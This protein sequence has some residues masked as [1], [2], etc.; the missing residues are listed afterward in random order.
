MAFVV[1]HYTRQEIVLCVLNLTLDTNYICQNIREIFTQTNYRYIYQCS[2]LTSAR[3]PQADD[4]PSGLIIVAQKT[5][6]SARMAD[7]L[8]VY[9]ELIISE[10]M[11]KA[12]RFF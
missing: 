4:F 1:V 10:D 2:N 8:K 7:D 5:C 3:Q 9:F 12:P 6:Q 11:F